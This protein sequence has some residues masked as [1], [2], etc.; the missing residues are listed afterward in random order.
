[1]GILVASGTRLRKSEESFARVLDAYGRTLGRRHA[2]RV[3]ALVASKSSVL[4]G[5]HVS[6]LAVIERLRPGIPCDQVEIFAVVVGVAAGAILRARLGDHV[7]MQPAMRG[8]P[9]GNL[10]MTFQTLEGSFPGAKLVAGGTLR[11]SFQRLVGASE[12]AGRDL[13]VRAEERQQQERNDLNYACMRNKI[14]FG[15]RLNAAQ[16]RS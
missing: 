2:L 11:G 14:R 10:G 3:M 9:R 4:A 5:Q 6:S 13:R 15:L 12:R 8:N 7:G 16:I 1:M